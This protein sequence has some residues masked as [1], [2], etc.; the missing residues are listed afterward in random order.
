MKN[1]LLK[2]LT[3]CLLLIVLS[4]CSSSKGWVYR[5]NEYQQFSEPNSVI[6]NRNIAILAFSDKRS[7][8]NSN[9]LL[10]YMLP[11]SPFGYQNLSSPETVPIHINSGL[12]VN[13]NPKEDF[14]K[15][16]AEELNSS[17]VFKEAFFSNSTKDS[18]YYIAG[19]LVSTD[20]KGKLL[21]YGL[22]IY[23][24]FLWYIGFPATH[25]SNDLEIKLSLI[26]TESKK[27]IFTKNYKADSYNK[28]GWIYDMPNDFKYPEMLKSLYKEFVLDVVEKSKI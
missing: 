28:L 20:Y 4:S 13:F 10:L 19:E 25:I 15:A 1:L 5:P 22:S 6:K 8:K 24:P 3:I 26:K 27:V 9:A 11:L 7:N 2:N 18:E 21:S 12:W 23:G 14:A 17:G 16:L